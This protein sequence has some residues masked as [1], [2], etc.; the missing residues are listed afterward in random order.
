MPTASNPA[1]SRCTWPDRADPDRV[2]ERE[3]V[4]AQ[5]HQSPAHLDDLRHRHGALPRVAETHRD[6]AANPQ[7]LGPSTLDDRREHGQRLLDAAVEVLAGERLGGAAEHRDRPHTRGQ[8]PVQPTLVGHEHGSLRTA[9]LLVEQP[10]HLLGV[11][12]LRHPPRVDERRGLDRA[13]T[14]AGQ[15]PAR[16]RPS[17]PPAPPPTRSGG[18]LVARP[19]RSS[20]SR[21]GL[22]RARPAAAEVSPADPDTPHAS[23]RRPHALPS[24]RHA[25]R[26]RPGDDAG[27]EGQR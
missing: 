1:S 5:V 27:H 17:P 19:R 20:R 21:A 26:R 2:A 25:I 10:E 18:R 6:V 14:R 11:G 4:A 15:A 16:T 13:Q 24:S 22:R 8:R 9:P 12:Q 7:P 23:W 3:L